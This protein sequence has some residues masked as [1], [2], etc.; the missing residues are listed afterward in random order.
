MRIT[1]N[2]D[3]SLMARLKE[4]ATRQRRPMSELVETALRLLFQAQK[5]EHPLPALP[6]FRSN[7]HLVNIANRDALHRAMEDR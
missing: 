1:L 3:D 6:S 7:G 2:I 5:S 4:E